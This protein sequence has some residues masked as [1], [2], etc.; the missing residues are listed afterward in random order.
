[1]LKSN[2]DFVMQNYEI[3][4]PSHSEFDMLQREFSV[5]IV[6]IQK[7]LYLRRTKTSKAMTVNEARHKTRLY[8]NGI[9]YI[10]VPKRLHACTT[11]G[12]CM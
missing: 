8:I 5:I 7:S 2:V 1:M 6:L 10:H 3:E 12:T 9:R 11:R 4:V